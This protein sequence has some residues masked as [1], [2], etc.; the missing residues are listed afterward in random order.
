M[1]ATFDLQL[2]LMHV[3]VK[4]RKLELPI[5]LSIHVDDIIRDFRRPTADEVVSDVQASHEVLRAELQKLGMPLAAGK[6][7]IVATD[8]S[9]ARQVSHL[10]LGRGQSA[11]GSVR[12]LGADFGLAKKWKAARPVQTKRARAAKLRVRLAV[13]RL[14]SLPLGKIYFAGIRPAV[15]Y[16]CEVQGLTN[17][18]YQALHKGARAAAKYIALAVPRQIS[19]YASPTSSLPDF[20]RCG[21]LIL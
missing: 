11:V 1:S 9:L 17:E 21:P 6:E 4:H 16:A 15:T 12:R 18:A 8:A 7:Q 2:T 13:R 3:V 5:T 10:S 19:L 14:R 20:D